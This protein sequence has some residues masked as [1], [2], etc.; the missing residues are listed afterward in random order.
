[1]SRTGRLLS[2]GTTHSVHGR[3][4]L[5]DA[6]PFPEDRRTDPA[7]VRAYRAALAAPD[8]TG[9]GFA[10]LDGATEARLRHDRIPVIRGGSAET[11]W[12][13]VTFAP[14]GRTGIV[15]IVT[16]T[17]SPPAAG[18][19]G[20]LRL[21]RAAYTQL[22]EGGPLPAAPTAPEV[23]SDGDLRT[24]GDRRLGAAAAWVVRPPVPTGTGWIAVVTAAIGTDVA[25]VAAEAL[26]L[27]DAAPALVAA[28]RPRIQIAG[29][30]WPV[31]RA[32]HYALDCAT[33]RAGD[34]T[35]AILADHELLPLVW[36]R[37]AYYVCLL[38]G[39]LGPA[40]PGHGVL[41]AFVRWL[42]TVAERPGG[43]W[44]RASLA[45]GQAKD[46]AFQLDQ[47]L[48][49]VLLAARTG[50]FTA[51]ARAVMETLLARRTAFGLIATDETPADDH[52]AQPYHFSSHILLWHTLA[53]IGHPEAQAVRAAT[54]GAF[55]VNGAFAYAV[56]GPDGAGARQYHDAN[57]L[58]TALAPAWGFCTAADPRW[59]R[60]IGR[61]WSSENAGFF[62]GPPGV[63]G[64]LSGLGSLHTPHPW[65][66]GDL[67]ARIIAM[68]L[69]DAAGVAAADARL[70]RVQTWD[71]L[72][73][74]AYDE[75]TG[76]VASRHW[77][78]W[79]TA[80]R[81]ALALGPLYDGT[82]NTGARA[83]PG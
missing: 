36:T 72:L 57:D 25:A 21:G 13:L 74:E 70:D 39:A 79:P 62:A 1:M 27:A 9:A 16:G 54:L 69:N 81:A 8:R 37:D 55:S 22:T 6:P 14:S 66:L 50:L 33:V 23:A 43:W 45:S 4:V 17:G 63:L 10:F 12:E 64:G 32:I 77:F 7:A 67:Q 53:T 2:L 46:R 83:T 19:T 56:G 30:P 68:A 24:I 51:D 35:V 44:P 20:M 5:T 38:L 26:A 42:F 61:A 41:P 82:S 52:L 28:E 15:Q 49:P 65:P 34:G 29:W 58:P 73:P 71:G 59:R 76:A 18:W 80:L 3:V 11:A 48:Y 60:T 75:T 78:A 47:Q 31:R 40:D